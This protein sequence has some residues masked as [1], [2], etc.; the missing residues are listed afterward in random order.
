MNKKGFTLI[1]L[2]IVIGILAVLAT[3]TVL[4]LNPAELFRQARDSQR[5]SDLGSVKGAISLYL[6]TYSTPNLQNGTVAFS[7]ASN[8]TSDKPSVTNP[9]AGGIP[10]GA[11]N[12]FTQ[13]SNTATTS[14]AGSGWVRVD[15][16]AIQGGSPLSVL[17]TD[18][19]KTDSSL[20]YGYGCV[21]T[22]TNALTFEL[23]AKMESARYKHSPVGSD[24]VEGTDG[25]N[26]L[27][28]YEV[29]TYPSLAL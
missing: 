13:V 27:D 6:T 24:D 26:Q 7:C 2:L 25:G 29:G 23:D 5:I 14:V 4:V 16:S 8:F 20:Y 10:V 12:A 1:E 11:G 28:R 9:F 17:P 21:Q 19:N 22:G 18:P 3:V 15:F